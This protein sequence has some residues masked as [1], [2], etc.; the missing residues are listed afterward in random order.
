[1]SESVNITGPV[2]V[3]LEEQTFGSG[4][5]KQSFVVQVGDKYPQDICID[6]VKD[7]CAKVAA[8]NVGDLVSVQCNI[9][10][11]L[12][13]GKYYTNLQMWKLAVTTP[14]TAAAPVA[15]DPMEETLPF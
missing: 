9:K 4:F 15:D 1:M 6:A 3:I 2:T 11:R 13:N 5:T 14:A 10:G 12:Y 7:D 8:L